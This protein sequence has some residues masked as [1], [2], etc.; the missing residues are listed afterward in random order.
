MWCRRI[1]GHS[2]YH[3]PIA[4]LI[5]LGILVFVTVRGGWV[6]R[7][8]LHMWR[9]EA[10]GRTPLDIEES[11]EVCAF[12]V[13][14]LFPGRGLERGSIVVSTGMLDSLSADERSAPFCHGRAHLQFG[15]HRYLLVGQILVA[16]LPPMRPLMNRLYWLLERNQRFGCGDHWRRPTYCVMNRLNYIL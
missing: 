8:I 16:V 7:N 13:P 9:T 5:L 1:L 14:L 12:T 4:G 2:V 11:D 15:H 6:T 3:R 10:L